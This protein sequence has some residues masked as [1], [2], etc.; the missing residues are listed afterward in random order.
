MDQPSRAIEWGGNEPG[1][2][3]C[4]EDEGMP[5]KCL[6]EPIETLF[7]P[8]SGASNVGQISNRV[9]VELTEENVGKMFCLAGIGGHVS[10]LI[11]ST[12]AAKRIVGIDGYPVQCAKKTL[13][14]AGLEVTDHVVATELGIAKNHDLNLDPA[15]VA[16]VKAA[17]RDSLGGAA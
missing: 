1:V 12:K 15:D 4:V 2:P 16:K 6:C 5:E 14:H 13:E 10:G 17:V 11:E 3:A 7:F 8:C 9:A